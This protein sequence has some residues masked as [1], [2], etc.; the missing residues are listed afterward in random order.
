MHWIVQRPFTHYLLNTSIKAVTLQNCLIIEINVSRKFVRPN[1]S[2]WLGG[3]EET[4]FEKKLCTLNKI[5]SCFIVGTKSKHFNFIT[6]CV[7][8]QSV[9]YQGAQ[10]CNSCSFYAIFLR[11]SPNFLFNEF[12][13]WSIFCWTKCQVKGG[14][15]EISSVNVSDISIF[16]IYAKQ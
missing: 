8:F 16:N 11:F 13:P 14:G 2:N 6:K 4:H 12:V 9:L 5:F 7:I 15:G 1:S 3:A 10:Q